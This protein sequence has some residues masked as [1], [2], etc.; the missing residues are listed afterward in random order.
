MTATI[1]TILGYLKTTLET[2]TT[3]NGYNFTVGQVYDDVTDLSNVNVS[4][5]ILIGDAVQRPEPGPA[6]YTRQWWTIPL[7]IYLTGVDN[8]QS[9]VN[10]AEHD[11]K[12]AILN[13]ASSPHKLLGYVAEPVI[14]TILKAAEPQNGAGLVG[15]EIEYYVLEDDTA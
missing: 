9:D 1:Q 6:G 14:R 4:R 3:G 8:P 7:D 5:S 13:Y 11:V 15:M 10:Y 12:K 2:I